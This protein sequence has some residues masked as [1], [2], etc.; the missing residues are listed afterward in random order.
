MKLVEFLNKEYLDNPYVLAQCSDELIFSKLNDCKDI[1]K[2]KENKYLDIRIFNQDYEYRLFRPDFSSEAKYIEHIDDKDKEENVDYYD[3]FQFLDIDETYHKDNKGRV[4]ST[5]GGFYPLPCEGDIS[6]LGLKIR[7]YVSYY[8]ETGQ[9]YV[10]D[11]RILAIEK[12]KE[13][14]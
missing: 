14:K 4:K 9:A 8:K 12:Y 2:E 5:G 6:D 11:F 13:E 10:S 3:E 1:L 7:N